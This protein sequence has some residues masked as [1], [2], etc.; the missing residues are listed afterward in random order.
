[1]VQKG[2]GQFGNNLGEATHDR[3][4]RALTRIITRSETKTP[5]TR[6]TNTLSSALGCIANITVS[7]KSQ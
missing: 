1:M 5:R 7:L 6:S 2:I 3:V 4:G